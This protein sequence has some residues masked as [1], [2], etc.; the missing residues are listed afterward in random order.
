MK[1]KLKISLCIS[2]FSLLI[3]HT[4]S[5]N[6]VVD[7]YA[8]DFGNL[9]YTTGTD[10]NLCG[11]SVR[12]SNGKGNIPRRKYQNKLQGFAD[13]MFDWSRGKFGYDSVRIANQAV[14]N[15]TGQG[16]DSLLHSAKK[17][18][19][20]GACNLSV[21]AGA[22]KGS[23]APSR[24]RAN[25]GGSGLTKYCLRHE[26]GHT[27]GLDHDGTY[28]G[29]N[30]KK[31]GGGE[32]QMSGYKTGFQIPHLHW[33][34]WL[35]DNE[36]KQLQWTDANADN[37]V[38]GEHWISTRPLTVD[39]PSDEGVYP[40]GLV[41]DLR[42]SGNRLWLSSNSEGGLKLPGKS[43]YSKKKD[44]LLGI[45]SPPF[46]TKGFSSI[47]RW[48][49]TAIYRF[50]DENKPWDDKLMDDIIVS[51]VTRTSNA[52]LIKI[53]E[54]DT[55]GSCSELPEANYRI[56]KNKSSINTLGKLGQHNLNIGFKFELNY[57]NRDSKCSNNMC[58]V[59]RL[60]PKNLWDTCYFEDDQDKTNLLENG[61]VKISPTASI[62]HP[63]CQSPMTFKTV[64]TK[65]DRD[66]YLDKF[67]K[68]I[69]CKPAYQCL[70]KINDAITF[71]VNGDRQVGVTQDVG[72]QTIYPN[73]WKNIVARERNGDEWTNG[74]YRST[75][76]STS[77][78]VKI[79][80]EDFDAKKGSI[81]HKRKRDSK[82]N[83]IAN[84]GFIKTGDWVKY[85]NVNFGGTGMN[86]FTARIATK[87]KTTYG[88]IDIYL[89][90]MQG[91]PAGTFSEISGG[92]WRN[93]SVD[94]ISLDQ[95]IIGTHDLYLK[96]KSG[97]NLDWFTFS[98][99]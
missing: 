94:S 1:N 30:C 9:P 29:N 45:L 23:N 47:E 10:K 3:A 65:Y 51:V 40:Y 66:F 41:V 59:S 44:S 22:F 12:F 81:R 82:G 25:C 2:A 80:A 24:T 46:G 72:I 75:D 83:A 14:V 68:N 42:R 18:R 6:S 55:L 27:W 84:L 21:F 39:S 79:E 15:D 35:E 96:F 49:E 48:K 54:S 98:A 11:Y 64:F 67:S 4:S 85:S 36:V 87:R 61:K 58:D 19:I 86:V 90:N 73:Q 99:D 74:P 26:A 70:Y 78:F 56:I 95:S 7:N 34:G 76:T 89:D 97:Y 77:T 33:L 37:Y 8:D 13:D 20:L 5:A 63:T 43:G 57:T 62:K 91:T 32:S 50:I 93:F 71:P 31:L 17:G 53:E 16:K 38:F 52:M 28:D 92:G 69:I 88:S 60:S